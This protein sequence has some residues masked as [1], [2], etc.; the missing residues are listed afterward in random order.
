MTPSSPLRTTVR[1]TYVPVVVGLAGLVIWFADRGAHLALGL[2]LATAV[3]LSFAA[4][5]LAAYDRT[6]NQDHDDRGRDALHAIVNETLNLA[7]VA[8]LPLIATTLVVADI[9]PT[10]WAF[11]LQVALAVIVFDAGVTLAHRASHRQRI[12]WSFHAVHHSV[13]RFYGLNGLMKHPVHQA[14][15]MTAG[16]AVLVVIGL[17]RNV[18]IALAGLTVIQLLLQHSNVDYAVGPLGRW[19]ALNAGHRLHHLSQPGAGDTNVGLYTLVWDRLLRTYTRPE[20]RP[21]IATADI[22]VTGRP[23]YPTAYTAQI[24]QPFRD[25]ARHSSNTTVRT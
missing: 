20:A 22:G 21:T 1:L 7:S 18:A 17:P 19:W 25:L 3:A 11:P 5:R 14:I 6:W 24:T 2:T 12:L 10:S 13:P 15:E 23:D 4:E 9:W 16:V 8:A